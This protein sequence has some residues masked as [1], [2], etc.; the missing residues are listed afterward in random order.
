MNTKS[1]T[2]V[3]L[4]LVFSTY[5]AKTQLSTSTMYDSLHY[6][7]FIGGEGL[8][9]AWPFPSIIY[10][11]DGSIYLA[12][13]TKS[14]DFLATTA[15][16]NQFEPGEFNLFVIH[17]MPDSRG[18]IS[19]AILGPVDT[20]RSAV[21]TLD[22]SGNILVGGFTKSPNFELIGSGYQSAY[23][24]GT[25][26]IIIKLNPELDQIIKQTY[27]GGSG[28][29]ELYSIRIIGTSLYMSGTTL[30]NNLP[31]H[32][33]AFQS[34]FAGT[35]TGETDL[36]IAYFD[37][38]LNI[39]LGCTYLGGAGLEAGY[40]CQSGE[41]VLISGF[42]G[43]SSYPVTNGA[44]DTSF[45]GFLDI[46]VTRLS[47]D[48]STLEAS[49][50]IGGGGGDFSY[51][52]TI[53]AESNVYLTGHGAPGFPVTVGAY[54][55][56][57]NGGPEGYDDVVVAKLNPNLSALEAATFIGGNQFE[58]GIKI[59]IDPEDN[60][61]VGGF[62]YSANYPTARNGWDLTHGGG[63][64]LFITT[65][66]PSLSDLVFSS[67]LGGSGDDREMTMLITPEENLIV[68]S[69]TTSSD[70]EITTGS[71]SSSLG[72]TADLCLFIF[73]ENTNIS[74]VDQDPHTGNSVEFKFYNNTLHYSFWIDEPQSISF[75]LM[76]L[77]GKRI[78][79]LQEFIDQAGDIKRMVSL[80]KQ[81]TGH[82]PGVFIGRVTGA[83]FVNSMKLFIY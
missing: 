20:F 83:Y 61:L 68:A 17:F 7:T 46:M 80:T 3:I 6:S 41:S 59:L 30:S 71:I 38:N 26:A 35:I 31:V 50:F 4:L 77:Q 54:D 43:S 48:L 8:E 81:W 21:L 64:D 67:F 40:L 22:N 14:S 47:D 25:D 57:Y 73:G 76:D 18:I 32:N 9:E 49:T 82:T 75:E 45:N 60:I 2:L 29:D 70:L 19:G 12:G 1:I 37:Q 44:Y 69:E 13:L 62:T 53:D 36:W 74:S 65:L 16:I 28:N 55:R 24:G 79:E 66:N 10:Q 15:I 23:A 34:T 42:T 27:F 63:A 11:P 72:G 39:L 52:C 58:N 5:T 56:T 33:T 51:D 78:L